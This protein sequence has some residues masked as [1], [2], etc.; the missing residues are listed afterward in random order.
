[1]LA[2]LV[3]A[4]AVHGLRLGAVIQVASFVGFWSGLA[5]GVAVALVAAKPLAAGNARAVITLV[6][7]LGLAALFGMAG[8]VLGGWAAVAMRR[9]RPGRA[10]HRCAW[11]ICCR[12]VRG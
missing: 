10:L 7:V 9:L 2:V 8:R 12:I 11:S 5:L 4:A 6:L 1:M 3:V